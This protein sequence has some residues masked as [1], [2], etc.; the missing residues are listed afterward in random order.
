MN[1]KDGAQVRAERI[2]EMG[3]TLEEVLRET[4]EVGYSYMIL[5]FQKKYGLRKQTVIEYLEVL[6]NDFNIDAITDK[7]SR[8]KDSES[9]VT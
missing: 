2:R 4:D 1:Y 7:I 6:S 5:T 9:I 8:V 3:K